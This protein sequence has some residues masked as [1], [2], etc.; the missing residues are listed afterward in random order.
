MTKEAPCRSLSFGMAEK[1]KA[2]NN[3]PLFLPFEPDICFQFVS[4]RY[5]SGAIFGDFEPGR[6]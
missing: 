4:R 2:G 5:E 1:T 3:K 6:G